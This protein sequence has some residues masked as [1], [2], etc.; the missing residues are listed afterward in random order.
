MRIDITRYECGILIDYLTGN[1]LKCDRKHA[2]ELCNQLKARYKGEEKPDPK[3]T[4]VPMGLI[5]SPHLD[6]H[7]RPAK[8]RNWSYQTPRKPKV[9]TKVTP[10]P[11]LSAEDILNSI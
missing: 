10:K 5:R 3:R 9:S 11:K 6:A 7:I 4:F 1:P 2:E 8:K